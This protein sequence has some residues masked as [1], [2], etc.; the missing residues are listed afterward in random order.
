MRYNFPRYYWRLPQIVSYVNVN[1]RRSCKSSHYVNVCRTVYV[2]DYVIGWVICRL[3]PIGDQD[4]ENYSGNCNCNTYVV[5]K[6]AMVAVKIFEIVTK[7]R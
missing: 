4:F 1:Y 7:V 6:D 3:G 2:I 5:G